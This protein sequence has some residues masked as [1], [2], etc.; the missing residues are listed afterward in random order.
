MTNGLI[1]LT[2][3]CVRPLTPDS[4]GDLDPVANSPLVGDR[5]PTSPN[6]PPSQARKKKAPSTRRIGT[7][8]E[9]VGEEQGT[10]NEPPEATVM[11]IG[12]SVKSGS[13]RYKLLKFRVGIVYIASPAR[14]ASVFLCSVML[15]SLIASDLGPL[16]LTFTTWHAGNLHSLIL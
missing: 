16:S 9:R 4:C 14:F 15:S 13:F 12:L 1:G 10:G 3:A 2:A 5:Y 6:P 11:P 8:P 7:R